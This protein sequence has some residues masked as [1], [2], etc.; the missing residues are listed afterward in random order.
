MDA[1]FLAAGFTVL[2]E[3]MNTRSPSSGF[4]L[5]VVLWSIGIMSVT[6]VGLTMLVQVQLDEHTAH[7]RQFR[8]RLLAESGLAVALSPQVKGG[9]PILQ[10]KISAEQRYEVTIRSEGERLN[11]NALLERKQESVLQRLW[12]Q[13]GM[14]LEEAQAL[15][16]ALLD[17]I[18]VD[19]LRRLNGAERTTYLE[20]KLPQLPTNKIFRTLDEVTQVIG[21]AAIEKLRPNWRDYFTL[22]SDGKLDLHAAPAELI[23]AFLNIPLTQ[24]ESFVKVRDPDGKRDTGD[25]IRFADVEAARMRLG[26]SEES[27]KRYTEQLSVESPVTR[28]ESHGIVG[29]YRYTLMVVTKKESKGRNF[30]LWQES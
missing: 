24:A 5:L 20:R 14:E 28:I 2:R 4:A 8:A 15:N 17:W 18:D 23:A 3:S 16:D 25:E 10:K 12:I 21:F 1:N 26:I 19:E 27:Y 30:L 9:D 7:A 11:L 6:V 22:W 29:R 13:W